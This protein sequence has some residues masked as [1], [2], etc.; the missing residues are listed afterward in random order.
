M[1]KK[2]ISSFSGSVASTVASPVQSG[3]VVGFKSKPV[4]LREIESVLSSI[5]VP[6]LDQIDISSMLRLV[7]STGEP[8]LSLTNPALSYEIFFLLTSDQLNQHYRTVFAKSGKEVTNLI[9]YQHLS[10]FFSNFTPQSYKKADLLQTLLY[11]KEKTEYDAE[12]ER[13]KSSYSIVE[14]VSQCKKCGSFNTLTYES[15]NRSADEASAEVV[16]CLSC[17]T[18]TSD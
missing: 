8:V 16:K 9:L 13:L 1:R 4:E 6:N 7:W 12:T 15:Q 17:K 11:K 14:G 18:Q 3:P 10:Q 5:E 2:P